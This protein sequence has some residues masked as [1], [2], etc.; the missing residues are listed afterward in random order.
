MARSVRLTVWD[1]RG[2]EVCPDTMPGLLS[3]L[4]LCASTS[5]TWEM[6]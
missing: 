4:S 3:V 5:F 1:G 2:L 6:V